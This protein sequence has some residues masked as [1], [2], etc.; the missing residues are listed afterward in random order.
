MTNFVP[1]YKE[2]IYVVPNKT[3]KVF[4]KELSIDV[5]IKNFHTISKVIDARIPNKTLDFKR[6]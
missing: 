4:Q 2:C 6:M 5:I 3:L 1:K